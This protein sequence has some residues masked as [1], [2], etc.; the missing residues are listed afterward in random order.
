MKFCQMDVRIITKLA[1]QNADDKISLEMNIIRL[2]F[3]VIS[4]HKSQYIY[5]KYSLVKNVNV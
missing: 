3:T 2:L 4:V 1:T 5:M